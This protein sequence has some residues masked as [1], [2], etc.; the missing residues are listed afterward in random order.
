MIF[1]SSKLIKLDPITLWKHTEQE[2]YV[3]AHHPPT[4]E[5]NIWIKMGEYPTYKNKG[6][7]K[8]VYE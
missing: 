6:N 1:K 3:L 5:N 2:E 7:A 8:A 4:K